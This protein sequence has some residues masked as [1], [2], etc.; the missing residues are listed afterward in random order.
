[1][2]GAVFVFDHRV[3][4]VSGEGVPLPLAP[5][6]YADRER[7]RPGAWFRDQPLPRPA[8]KNLTPPPVKAKRVTIPKPPKVKVGGPRACWARDHAAEVTTRYMDG[9]SIKSLACDLGVSNA[10]I[11]N[12]IRFG[13]G[14]LRPHGTNQWSEA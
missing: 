1:M 9:E 3:G 11:R 7:P 4:G 2:T 13:G 10:A 8:K 6:R 12:A 5:V 14:E